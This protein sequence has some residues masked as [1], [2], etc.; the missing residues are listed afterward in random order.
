MSNTSLRL[1]SRSLK[2]RYTYLKHSRHQVLEMFMHKVNIYPYEYSQIS[3]QIPPVYRN[4]SVLDQQPPA[5]EEVG[6]QKSEQVRF[7]PV[8]RGPGPSQD[9]EVSKDCKPWQ[10]QLQSQDSQE[11][12]SV[13]LKEGKKVL[14][15]N[16]LFLLLHKEAV[17]Q[18][19]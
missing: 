5:V 16:T 6:F 9:D 10:D 8:R 17:F 13:C 15:V 3:T 4:V 11:K 7:V 18:K 19:A 2:P 1:Y 12:N 14:E